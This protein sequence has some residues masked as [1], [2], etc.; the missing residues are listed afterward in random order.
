MPITR[1]DNS[2]RHEL[3]M[4]LDYT[5]YIRKNGVVVVVVVSTGLSYI[6]QTRNRWKTVK[7][8]EGGNTTI[9]FFWDNKYF[10]WKLYHYCSIPLNAP[11]LLY[12]ITGTV[13]TGPTKLRFPFHAPGLHAASET[14][15]EP[16]VGYREELK[17]P[18]VAYLIGREVNFSWTWSYTTKRHIQHDRFCGLGRLHLILRDGN[19][20]AGLQ[21]WNG[22]TM[23]ILFQF[24]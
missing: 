10:K 20:L 16:C 11:H 15:R 21:H 17:L 6:G 1:R 19:T 12:I 4:S 22:N 24:F 9:I 2:Q 13:I 18:G 8:K 5:L 3:C 23:A 7:Y 14:T